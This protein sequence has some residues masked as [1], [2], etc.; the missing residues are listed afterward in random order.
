MTMNE[1]LSPEQA[2]CIKFQSDT[3]K[4]TPE[5]P[6]MDFYTILEAMWE[7]KMELKSLIFIEQ[8][9]QNTTMFARASL[10]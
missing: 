3:T 1:N 4:S 5:A 2:K 7:S 10:Y 6:K 8:S 9:Q